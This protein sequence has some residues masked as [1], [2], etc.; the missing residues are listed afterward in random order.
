MFP[1][2][3]DLAIGRHTKLKLTVNLTNH[4]YFT[5]VHGMPNIGPWLE[6]HFFIFISNSQT[7]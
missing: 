2:F 1:I 6:L 3:D 7:Y 5:N 4:F